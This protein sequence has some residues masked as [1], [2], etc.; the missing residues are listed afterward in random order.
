M[1][2]KVCL[3]AAIGLGLFGAWVWL[4]LWADARNQRFFQ[5]EETRRGAREWLD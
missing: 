4:A 1:K 5:A 2:Q 3:G